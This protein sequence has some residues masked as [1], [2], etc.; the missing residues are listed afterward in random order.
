MIVET[1]K[2]FV[3]MTLTLVLYLGLFRAFAG[4]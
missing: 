1:G 2:T 4:E 3:E